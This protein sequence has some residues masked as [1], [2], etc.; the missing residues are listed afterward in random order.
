MG[1][2]GS[3]DRVSMGVRVSKGDGGLDGG[4]WDDGVSRGSRQSSGRRVLE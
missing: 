4:S 3:S 2:V 1:G